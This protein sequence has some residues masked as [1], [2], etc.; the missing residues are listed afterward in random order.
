MGIAPVP[1]PPHTQT[2]TLV[3]KHKVFQP[4]KDK[5]QTKASKKC[6][7]N[8]R[9]NQPP[10]KKYKRW[11]CTTINFYLKKADHLKACSGDNS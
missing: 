4:L 1:P 5:L 11:Y 8:T 9:L 6:F 10:L 7:G 3:F 2:Q